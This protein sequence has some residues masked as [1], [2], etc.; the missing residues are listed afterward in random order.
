VQDVSPS[1]PIAAWV[2]ILIAGGASYL[3]FKCKCTR[4]DYDLV[5][6]EAGGSLVLPRTCGRS[7][8][9]TVLRRNIVSIGMEELQSRDTR[10]RTHLGGYAATLFFTGPDGTRRQERLAKLSD[11]Y[12]AQGLVAWLCQR[13]HV[14]PGGSLSDSESQDA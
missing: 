13:M 9:V 3:Y 1:V 14:R 5:I 10:G 11:T 6:D 8:V 7:E 4:G 12:S 2:L